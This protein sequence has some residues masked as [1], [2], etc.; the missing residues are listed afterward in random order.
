MKNT[1]NIKIFLDYVFW[2]L[3]WVLLG[4]VIVGAV[5]F[6]IYFWAVILAFGLC[7]IV[8]LGVLVFIVKLFTG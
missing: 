6:L 1:N 8:V 5:I 2:L 3:I 4:L 7:C